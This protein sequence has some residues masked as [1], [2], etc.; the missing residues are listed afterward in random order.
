MY[1][2]G[3]LVLSLAM[4][5]S[6]L[7]IVRKFL[8]AFLEKKQMNI[9]GIG[10]WILFTVLQIIIEYYRGTA[11][12]WKF[13]FNVLIVCLICVCNYQWEGIRNILFVLL[14]LVMWALI[15]M[16]V[17][18]GLQKIFVDERQVA[19]IGVVISKI[20]VIVCVYLFS[21]YAKRKENGI[22]P[23]KY[24]VALLFVPVGSIY[25]A[26]ILFNA[27]GDYNSFSTMVIFSILLF[28][29][30]V[31]FELYDKIMESF[32]LEK[33]KTIYSQQ[34]EM[35]SKNT[36][37]Q[38]KM[39][40]AF[41]REKHNWVNELIVLKNS[42]GSSDENI[43][44]E[45]IDRIIHIC[46]ASDKVSD[47]GNSI[48]DAVLNAKYSMAKELGIGFNVKVFVSE[49][50]PINQY[51]LGVVLGN[52]IDNAID[53]V[54]KCKTHKKIIDISV[55]IKKE[56]LVI[57]VKNPYEHYLIKDKK[58]NLLSTKSGSG[59]H[60]YGISSIKRIAEKYDGEVIWDDK[61]EKFSV[62]IFMN[63]QKF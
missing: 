58:G 33:E 32:L 42:V 4:V 14:F 15:E 1:N 24:Y 39:M 12:I 3:N 19:A 62:V 55:G 31:I 54:K 35:L 5:I 46:N 13:V 10:A 41:Y 18:F 22:I 28:I 2:L 21:I 48:I 43:V 47:S 34:L 25:I 38:K 44:S 36:E 50:L 40:E 7:W 29:N 63:L 26:H 16:I 53:A 30:I 56:M 23:I 51:E 52:A 27:D 57:T 11:S 59:H 61:D 37:E 49:K 45:E 9:W 6:S 20:L 60:G 8:D 17:F